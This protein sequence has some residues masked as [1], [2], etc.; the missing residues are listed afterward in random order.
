MFNGFVS[1]SLKSFGVIYV[2]LLEV[3]NAG[4]FMTSLNSTVHNL[5]GIFYS[6][7]TRDVGLNICASSCSCTLHG[8][9]TIDFSNANKRVQQNKHYS[10]L[11]T[12]ASP[13]MTPHIH[14]LVPTCVF[15][16][17]NNSGFKCLSFSLS[18]KKADSFCFFGR[19]FHSQVPSYLLVGILCLIF[20]SGVLAGWLV[21]KIGIR[22]VGFLGTT[23][24]LIGLTI[25]AF[26]SSIYFVLVG[27]GVIAGILHALFSR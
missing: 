9:R 2:E 4:E 24:G 11:S 15:Q 22:P 27:Y 17:Q 5:C 18:P 25:A 19:L 3:Y 7:K 12:M 8:V 20:D 6:K 23:C 13:P 16:Q 14:V 26:G 1:A 10:G 21:D